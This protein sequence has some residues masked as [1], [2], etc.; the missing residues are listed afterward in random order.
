MI[1]S[2]IRTIF[3]I[4]ILLVLS[5]CM[6]F[7]SSPSN[8]QYAY[9]K[10]GLGLPKGKDLYLARNIWYTDPDRISAV[11]YLTGKILPFGTKVKLIEVFPGYVIFRTPNDGKK[12]TIVNNST[13]TLFPDLDIFDSIFTDKTPKKLEQ[14]IKSENLIL[15]KTGTIKPGMTRREVKMALGLPFRGF[16]PLGEKITWVYFYNADLKAKHVVF[17][18]DDIVIDVFDC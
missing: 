4:A 1:Y 13:Y 5:S 9:D 18:D 6:Y 15:L 12:Y 17:N 3:G 7:P 10:Y 14:G 8:L 2:K 16:T 11:N